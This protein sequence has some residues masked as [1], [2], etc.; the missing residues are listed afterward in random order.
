MVTPSLS[1]VAFVTTNAFVSFAVEGV[2]T[3]MP[4]ALSN[5]CSADSSAFGSD[6]SLSAALASLPL[7]S[8]PRYSGLMSICPLCSAGSEIS[9]VPRS[10]LRLTV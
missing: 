7:S 8:D 2:R 4:F 9:R 3:V 5:G 10:R 6:D 1:A